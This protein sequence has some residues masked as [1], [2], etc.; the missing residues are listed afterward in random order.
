MSQ[1][2]ITARTAS[3]G[4]LVRITTNARTHLLGIVREN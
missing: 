1:Q 4:T 2:Y 3:G